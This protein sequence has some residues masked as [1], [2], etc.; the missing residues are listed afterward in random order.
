[1]KSRKKSALAHDDRWRM[2]VLRYALFGVVGIIILRL[3]F[4]QVVNAGF[5]GSLADG[6]HTF[7]QE[8]IAERGTVWVRD[9]KD[10]SEYAAATNEATGFVY[11]E[12]RKVE[13]PEETA[14]M[15]ARI[16]G[17]EVHRTSVVDDVVKEGE[18]PEEDAVEQGPTDYEILLARLSKENDPYEPVA[19]NVSQTVLDQIIAADLDGVYYV[20]EKTRSYPEK[21]LGGHVFGFLAQTAS[22]SFGQYGLEGYFDEYLAGTNGFL[23]VVTDSG[24]SWIGV[25]KREFQQ[26]S[27]GGDLLLTIDRTVQYEICRLLAEGVQRYDATS[28]S[29]VVLE[30][31]TG[32]VMAMCNAPDFDPN[33]YNNVEDVS[34]YNN[35]SIFTP[36][37]PGSVMKPLVVAG[38]IDV[39]AISPSQTYEDT[40]EEKIDQYTIRNSDLK[41][42][43]VQTMTQ[44]LEQSLNTGMIYIMRQMGGPVMTQYFEDFGFG[45]LTGISLDTESAGTISALYKDT[46]I[47]YATGSY[48][49]GI[50][51]TLLQLASAYG[52]LA[53]NGWLMEPYVVQEYRYADG[54]IEEVVP[55]RVR[56]VVQEST[57]TTVGA[58]LVSVIEHGHGDKAAVEGYYLAGKTGTA[59]V[60]RQDGAGYQEGVTN[61]TFTG[62]G[63]IEDPQFVIV[64][65]LEHPK[66][67]QWASD[68]AAPIFSQMAEFLLDYLEIPPTRR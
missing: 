25:G 45:T 44:V 10:G 29:V 36:Y 32:R 35:N 28:G 64:V 40:G 63:P 23:D 26:A 18:E 16:L 61:A 11:A 1:M 41:A 53:N 3:F 56:H 68:T 58:M 51:T 59:Q 13:D 49:Q 24:G 38:A 20:L 30:P 43:G 60:A 6:Q 33:E 34:I 37:E 62:Y 12:P 42:H 52:A 66:A 31:A 50:T 5:Y 7:Y 54:T 22:G 55:R 4:L 57:A 47:Y 21:K 9:W 39:G 2:R 8:L 65:K 14:Q 17:Y 67:V 19:R 48:G 46:E 27:D 15:L